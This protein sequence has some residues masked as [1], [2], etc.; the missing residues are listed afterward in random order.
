MLTPS[1]YKAL[2]ITVLLFSILALGLLNIHLQGEEEEQLFSVEYYFEEKEEKDDVIEEEPEQSEALE[3]HR[4]YNEA[5]K[6][7]IKTE[8]LVESSQDE[9]ERHIQAID[10]ALKNSD[11]QPTLPEASFKETYSQSDEVI[12]NENVKR[13]SSVSYF[14]EN[15]T[16]LQL[17]SPVYTCPR[18]GTIV[19]NI[20]VNNLGEVINTNVDN[21]KSSTS[22]KCLNEQA[23]KYAK[24]AKFNASE[25]SNE[26]QKGTITYRFIWS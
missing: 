2:L 25:S 9:F 12:H 10:E 24:Q 7:L 3:T 21:S 11:K 1:T 15:R 20:T 17:P 16:A 18:G 4:A 14:L 8:H 5:E 6:E 23:L 19:V 26:N 22:D 13:T